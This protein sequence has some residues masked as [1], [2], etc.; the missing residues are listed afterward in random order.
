MASQRALEERAAEQARTEALVAPK[1]GQEPIFAKRSETYYDHNF[2]FFNIVILIACIVVIVIL[3]KNRWGTVSKRALAF[4][5]LLKKHRNASILLAL[6]VVLTISI[7]SGIDSRWK[8][9]LSRNF[10][11]TFENIKA[12]FYTKKFISVPTKEYNE[13]LQCKRTIIP[14]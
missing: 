6:L 3:L 14:F 7:I 11:N 9:E 12:E 4:R 10:S 13:Y 2:N 8:R 5:E 1:C